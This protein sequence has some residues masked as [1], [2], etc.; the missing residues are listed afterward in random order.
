MWQVATTAEMHIER[1][2]CRAEDAQWKQL[3]V[4]KHLQAFAPA[5]NV[6]CSVEGTVLSSCLC[7]VKMH[8]HSGKQ[9]LF[10]TILET[11]NT[12]VT[13]IFNSISSPLHNLFKNV[14]RCNSYCICF[15]KIL[16]PAHLH[17]LCLY[18]DR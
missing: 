13:G 1:Q 4:C 3:A 15:T 2:L 10:K 18:V 16:S 14:S 12:E 17:W 8:F 7:K 11:V 6:Q 5:V 9:K